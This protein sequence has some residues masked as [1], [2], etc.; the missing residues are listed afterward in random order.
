MMNGNHDVLE[1]TPNG[2]DHAKDASVGHGAFT[3]NPAEGHDQA[4]F[5]VADHGTAHWT[6]T[7][8]NEELGQVDEG[9]K[10]TALHANI[11]EHSSGLGFFHCLPR[12]SLPTCS[13]AQLQ[14]QGTCLSME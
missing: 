6:S 3:C 13:L 7:D 11:S 10:A 1:N 5:H 2:Y 14:K 12:G 4:G 9:R 8:D